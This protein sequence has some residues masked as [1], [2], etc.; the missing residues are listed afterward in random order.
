MTI[1]S[2]KKENLLEDYGLKPVPAEKRK[3]WL[4]IGVVW[5]GV[6]IVMSALLRG[7]MVG[8][9]LGRISRVLLAFVFGELILIIM[10]A[11]SGY[12]G[13]RTGLSTPLIARTAFGDV[14]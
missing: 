1:N 5:V 2:K 10:M 12:I 13:A 11:L 4:S 14:G 3:H 9:G 7:M 6:A 8:M